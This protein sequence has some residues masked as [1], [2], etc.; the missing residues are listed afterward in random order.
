[1]VSGTLTKIDVELYNENDEKERCTVKIW[2]QPWL[3]NGYEVTFDCPNKELVKRRHSRSVEQLEKKTHK[4]R[5]H[6]SLDKTEHLF[7]KFQIKYNR[8]YHTAMEHQMRL[9]IFKQNLEI[10]KELNRNEMG[11]RETTYTYIDA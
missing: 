8:R 11:K 9:R 10:I 5:N 3:P 2:S 7:S 1:M 6:H 4:K